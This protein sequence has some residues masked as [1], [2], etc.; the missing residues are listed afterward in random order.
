MRP[1]CGFA[2]SRTPTSKSARRCTQTRRY[3]AGWFSTTD[4][5]AD[6]SWAP[7][8]LS[9]V[10]LPS[11]L[12]TAPS[13][14]A[15]HLVISPSRSVFPQTRWHTRSSD[16]T[17]SPPRD[18]DLAKVQRRRELPARVIPEL[19]VLAQDRLIA[20]NLKG[21]DRCNSSLRSHLEGVFVPNM[22]A[23]QTSVPPSTA[24]NGSSLTGPRNRRPHSVTHCHGTQSAPY[25]TKMRPT[26]SRLRR[27]TK[28]GGRWGL[29]AGPRFRLRRRQD[30]EC[31]TRSL[32]ASGS[33]GIASGAP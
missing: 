20:P 12:P 1:D 2:T 23:P 32:R 29:T 11:W 22:Y 26:P 9:G 19:Q 7:T 13:H 33:A 28:H 27:A 3:R 24:A 17:T 18:A 10:C 8:R 16:S 21:E 14:V 30:L 25:R 31:R 6:T 15:R 4:T 5:C